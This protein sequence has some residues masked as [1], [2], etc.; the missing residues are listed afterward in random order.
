MAE[1]LKSLLVAILNSD[2]LDEGIQVVAYKMLHQGYK[3][4]DQEW[5]ALVAVR[6][7]GGPQGYAGAWRAADKDAA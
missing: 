1:I 5:A 7:L 2:L 3:P 6:L 4:S